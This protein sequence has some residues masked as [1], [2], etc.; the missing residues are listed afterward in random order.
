VTEPDLTDIPETS[1]E[2]FRGA[3]LRFAKSETLLSCGRIAGESTDS[4]AARTLE[5]LSQLIGLC[6]RL[7]P[8]D[9]EAGLRH[10]VKIALWHLDTIEK[11]KGKDG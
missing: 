4:Y 1:E 2:W 6:P 5:W 9:P 8:G 3:R 11:H 7:H 10:V